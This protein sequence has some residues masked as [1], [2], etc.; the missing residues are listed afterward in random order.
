MQLQ[1]KLGIYKL[2]TLFTPYNPL[3]YFIY[4]YHFH[5]LGQCNIEH[6]ANH[7][8][9]LFYRASPLVIVF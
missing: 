5:H 3:L 2:L 7:I 9:F 4:T 6:D 8:G 1:P